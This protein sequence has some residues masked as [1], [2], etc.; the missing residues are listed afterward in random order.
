MMT[1]PKKNVKTDKVLQDSA[2]TRV[3][4]YEPKLRTF[5]SSEEIK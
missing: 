2:N 5:T 4:A 1:S 3:V